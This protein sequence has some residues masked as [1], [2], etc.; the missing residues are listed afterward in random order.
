MSTREFV[1]HGLNF[2]LPYQRDKWLVDSAS[3]CMVANEAFRELFLVKPAEVTITVG[4]DNQLKCTSVG[5][6]TIAT[7]QG[8]VKLQEVRIVPGFGV[9]ILSGPYLEKTLGL[10]LSS[11][12]KTWWARR[13]RRQV[14]KCEGDTRPRF[15]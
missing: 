1:G 15:F 9:N 14:L 11:D 2:R 7:A 12:G 10:S 6:L 4:G 13:R 8:P 3:T 5:N